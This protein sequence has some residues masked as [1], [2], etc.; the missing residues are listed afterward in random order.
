[1]FG[2][3]KSAAFRYSEQTVVGEEHITAAAPFALSR[4]GW[5]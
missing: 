4:S 2:E 1:M 3:Y 5:Q